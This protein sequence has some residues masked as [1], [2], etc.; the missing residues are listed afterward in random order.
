VRSSRTKAR[1]FRLDSRPHGN[2][3]SLR[4]PFFLLTTKWKFGKGWAAAHYGLYST[5]E[6]R[7]REAGLH[8]TR[9]KAVSSA[10]ALRSLPDRTELD[11]V[12]R[13]PAGATSICFLRLLITAT[14]HR[15]GAGRVQ[16]ALADYSPSRG[17][18]RIDG[19]RHGR[20]LPPPAR[21]NCPAQRALKQRYHLSQHY[22]Q[23]LQ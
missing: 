4:A 9:R 21:G 12:A 22:R 19:S 1:P 6:A 7:K 3:F 5:S 10:I 2:R 20:R 15:H 23:E 14:L 18:I 17:P 11:L 16:R 13:N 8:S